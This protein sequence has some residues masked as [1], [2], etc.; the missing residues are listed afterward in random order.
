MMS[1]PLFWCQLD[2]WVSISARADAGFAPDQAI[3]QSYCAIEVFLYRF[4][5]VY[6]ALGQCNDDLSEKFARR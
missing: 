3:I 1:F 5:R 2:L 6:R 4:H